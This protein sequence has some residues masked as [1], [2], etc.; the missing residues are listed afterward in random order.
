MNARLV[1]IHA[2]SPLHAGIGQGIG[3]IDLPIAREK[4]TGIPFL[5]G[6]SLKGSLRD[7]CYD[8]EKQTKI[9]G[10]EKNAE[11]HSGAAQFSD[12]RLLLLPVRSLLGTFAWV[13][14][15]YLLQRFARDA[16]AIGITYQFPSMP[17]PQTTNCLISVSSYLKEKK[18]EKVF[19]EDL[20]LN[21]TSDASAEKWADLFAKQLFSDDADGLDSM[22]K[23]FCVVS[24]D[25][26]SFLLETATEISARISL[27][28]ETK[29]VV[30]GS[31][32]YEEALPAETILSGLILSNPP[33]KFSNSKS[34]EISLT[35]EKIFDTIKSLVEKA[36][37]L[38]GKATVGHGLCSVKLVMLK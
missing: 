13:T 23:R 26:F 11:E 25:V 34:S 19:L 22:K 9:F 37:Q 8:K 30:K 36:I 21:A 10:P 31:L 2:L 15:P 12:Q 20:D 5:P 28:D 1:F 14:C 18:T 33:L 7:L 16:K 4:A 27:D 17:K 35:P 6:S 3:V 24:D 38:G 32:W 29:T